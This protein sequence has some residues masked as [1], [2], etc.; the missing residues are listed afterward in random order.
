MLWPLPC[1]FQV[2]CGHNCSIYNVLKC[3]SII[4][5]VVQS[6]LTHF[7]IHYCPIMGSSVCVLRK[8]W[9][10]AIWKP[11]QQQWFGGVCSMIMS[12]QVSFHVQG[13]PWLVQLPDLTVPDFFLWG[14]LKEFVYRNCPHNTG[15]EAC[16]SRWYCDYK[17]RA[18]VLSFFTLLSIV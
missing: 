16:Y 12:D 2:F 17:S 13:V 8:R 3:E 10:Y 7:R 15:A 5:Q 1:P 18:V 6:R 11:V 9:C 4:I 14:Y